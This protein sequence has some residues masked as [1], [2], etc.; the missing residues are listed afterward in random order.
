MVGKK[1]LH[2]T[3][4]IDLQSLPVGHQTFDEVIRSLVIGSGIF[5]CIWR[6]EIC[7]VNLGFWNN[8]EDILAENL[9]LFAVV[10]DQAV[11]PDDVIPEAV[12]EFFRCICTPVAAAPGCRGEVTIAA[13]SG[14]TGLG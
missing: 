14:N 7:Q 1:F 6:I 11:N 9:I 4:F 13:R 12:G 2:P 3:V 8:F 10:K 5:G